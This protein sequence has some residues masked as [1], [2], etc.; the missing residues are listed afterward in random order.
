VLLPL[1]SFLLAAWFV[2]PVARPAAH[3]STGAA[4]AFRDRVDEAE[5]L[6]TWTFVKPR[7]EAAYAEVACIT[8]GP[9]DDEAELTQ[10]VSRLAARH[11][12]VD[13]YLL[14][15]TNT[16]I[17]WV[18][19]LPEAVRARLRMVYNSGCRGGEQ[20]ARWREAGAQAYVAHPEA[21]THAG[22]FVC[23]LRRWPGGDRLDDVVAAANAAQDRLLAHLAALSPSCAEARG[24]WLRS[25]AEITGRTD[26]TL[27]PARGGP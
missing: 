15:H 27:A 5:I 6:L 17:E 13:I 4:V 23:F 14:A 3:G 26:L 1:A 7:L 19:A 21:A 20:A 11:A 2:D 18:E 16:V 9:G 10:A 24:R 12:F 25:H 8:Q 22:F